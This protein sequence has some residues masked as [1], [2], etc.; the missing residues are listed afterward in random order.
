MYDSEGRIINPYDWEKFSEEYKKIC[1]E[2]KQADLKGFDFKMALQERIKNE[3]TEEVVV[4]IKSGRTERMPI[5]RKD[6]NPLDKLTD[7]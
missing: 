3:L 5:F 2:L 4:D 1:K 7:V 6:E